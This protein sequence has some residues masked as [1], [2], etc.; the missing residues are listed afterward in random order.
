MKPAKLRLASALGLAAVAALPARAMTN[1]EL[2]P[3]LPPTLKSG[4]VTYM[5]GGISRDQQ[6]AMERVA[7]GYP[8]ELHFLASGPAYGPSYVPVKIR[9]RTGK[10]V[11]DAR[12]NGPLMLADVP[13]GHYTVSAR[14]AG[15]TERLDVNVEH[16]K[17][18]MLAFDWR[19]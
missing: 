11:L 18:E 13:D 4:A 12:S 15:K 9:D 10:V 16:G 8:L 2:N 6:S 17:H 14:H 19:R 3:E 7:S 1:P 5:S